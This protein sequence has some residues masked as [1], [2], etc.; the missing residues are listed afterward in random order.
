MQVFELSLS[1]IKTAHNKIN[2][3]FSIKS[4]C[5]PNKK[6]QVMAVCVCV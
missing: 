2:N 5:A 4:T 1:T 6:R 3:F